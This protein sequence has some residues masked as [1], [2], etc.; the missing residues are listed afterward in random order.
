MANDLLDSARV[1]LHAI[2]LEE[3]PTCLADATKQVLDRLI[4]AIGQHRIRFHASEER[5]QVA[6]D[7]ARFD[8]ILSNLIDN[9]VKFSPP[10]TPI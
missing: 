5:G 4:P 2:Q 1:D 7:P 8:Q 6:L 3:Q 10:D 9:A